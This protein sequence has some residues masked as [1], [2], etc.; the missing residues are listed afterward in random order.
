MPHADVLKIINVLDLPLRSVPGCVADGARLAAAGHKVRNM[1]VSVCVVGQR[2]ISAG[3]AVRIHYFNLPAFRTQKSEFKSF[4]T[5][6]VIRNTR[7]AIR[8]QRDAGARENLKNGWVPLFVMDSKHAP[9]GNK[10]LLEKGA[11]S[12]PNPLP[13]EHSKEFRNW[14]KSNSEK[15]QFHQVRYLFFLRF[16]S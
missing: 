14:L 12:M 4:L 15:F 13:I 10:M 16:Q 1:G 11:I 6:V 8:T 2:R 9:D 3:V 7:R 5:V